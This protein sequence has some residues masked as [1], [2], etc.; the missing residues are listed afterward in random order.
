MAEIKNKKG[1]ETAMKEEDLDK[2]LNQVTHSTIKI[3][4][5]HLESVLRFMN[6]AHRQLVKRVHGIERKIDQ[7]ERLEIMSDQIK[8]LENGSMETRVSISNI[9][10][11]I[12]EIEKKQLKYEDRINTL[13]KEMKVTKHTEKQL[14]AKIKQEIKTV[15]KEIKTVEA[16]IPVQIHK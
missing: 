10:A 5:T 8:Q 13:E 4:F 16:S 9:M 7:D 6:S 15:T 11:K 12:I 1:P 3:D 14:D 2:A